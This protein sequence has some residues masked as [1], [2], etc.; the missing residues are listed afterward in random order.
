[1]A[2]GRNL[3]VALEAIAFAEKFAAGSKSGAFR[4]AHFEMEFA[5]EALGARG[6]CRGETESAREQADARETDSAPFSVHC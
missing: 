5:A 2:V 1:V 6:G 3:E 4:I